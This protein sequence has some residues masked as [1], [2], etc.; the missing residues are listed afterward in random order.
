MNVILY[1]RSADPWVTSI[2]QDVQVAADARHK[3]IAAL[4]IETAVRAPREC[5]SVERL[6]VLPFDAPTFLPDE[7]PTATPRLLAALFPRA[8]LINPPGPHELCW[9]KLATAQRL[10]ERGV[11]MPETLITNDPEEALDFVRH[12]QQAMLKEP[13]ACGGHGHV[14]LLAG[15]GG[16]LAGEVPGRRYAIELQPSGFG[17]VLRHGVLSIP[18]PFYLQRLVTA[19]GRGGALRPAQV[20]RAY[21]VDGQV[22]FW[23]ER[24][25]DKVRRPADFIVSATFGAKYRF[26][27]AV[28]DSLDG[29][30]R[31]TADALGVRIGVVDVLRAG[32]DG[33]FVLEADTD[34]QH[35]LIDRGFK[36][37]PEYR[38]PFDFDRMIAD[39]LLTPA[40]DLRAAAV[41]RDAEPPQ[42]H[43]R[44][45]RDGVSSASRVRGRV[46]A[47]SDRTRGTGPR[48]FEPRSADPR[49]AGPRVGGPRP[50]R[51]R[52]AGTGGGASRWAAPRGSGPRPGGPRSVGPGGGPRAAGPRTGPGRGS[53]APPTGRGRPPR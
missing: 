6:Y 39:A 12:H 26:V 53:G 40:P 8:E 17:R 44:P 52:G 11:P 34:G 38:S 20:L 16:A 25:R 31:R 14:V 47:R 5:Q 23:T 46:V 32:D 33:P 30:A 27:R 35:M 18:P 7:L 37:L 45:S 4:S 22:A 2:I 42:P 51:P 3:E 13:R 49:D 19:S 50:D 48:R 10:L 36:N 15:D 29:L 21:V 1:G 24:Y 43:A 28:G 9:D 41:R